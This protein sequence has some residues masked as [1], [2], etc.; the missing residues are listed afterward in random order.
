MEDPFSNP[1]FG[2]QIIVG[3]PATISAIQVIPRVVEVVQPALVQVSC[4]DINKLQVA[5]QSPLNAVSG[6]FPLKLLGG[7]SAVASVGKAIHFY[8]IQG[9][10]T[11][12]IEEMSRELEEV[13]EENRRLCQQNKDLVDTMMAK[14][15]T[16]VEQ[17][18]QKHEE[19]MQEL[20]QYYEARLN[21]K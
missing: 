20:V 5:F 19:Q 10:N 18:N 6:W 7:C 1:L 2:A 21:E 3:T 15:Q 9:D 14:F 17:Q 8:L 13:K 11:E 16:I 4:L 12:Q